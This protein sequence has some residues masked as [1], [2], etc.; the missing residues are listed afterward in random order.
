MTLQQIIEKINANIDTTGNNLTTGAGLIEVLLDM[1]NASFNAPDQATTSLPEYST[2]VNYGIGLAVF[3]N[4]AIYV[5]LE[6]NGPSTIPNGLVEP[7][8]NPDV[9]AALD[10]FELA[11]LQNTDYKLGRYKKIVQPGDLVLGA[12]NLTL[13]EWNR[14]NYFAFGDVQDQLDTDFNVSLQSVDGSAVYEGLFFII[15]EYPNA[16]VT[17]D[18]DGNID[19]PGME[20]L[21]LDQGDWALCLGAV[22]LD[23]GKRTQIIASNKLTVQGEGLNIQ[24]AVIVETTDDP[25][26]NGEN[27]LASYMEA[28]TITPNGEALSATN[29]VTVIIPPGNYDLQSTPLTLDTQF[30]DIVGL[31]S[32]RKKQYIYGEPPAENSGVIVQTANDVR[33]LNFKVEI[34]TIGAG[35]TASS[36][37]AY[38]PNTNLINAYVENVEFVGGTIIEATP[39]LSMRRQVE[40]SGTFYHC[41]G[42]DGAFGGGGTAS[43]TFT[44]C[45]G[46]DETF[47]ESGTASGTFTNCKGE[48]GAFGGYGTASG[49]FTNC[50]GG[51][52]AFGGYGNASGTFSNC[53]GGQTSFGGGDGNL[54]GSLYFCRLTAGTFKAPEEAGKI[55]YCI[56]GNGDVH[57]EVNP[58]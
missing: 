39:C 19:I 31:T 24:S 30:I 57:T 35:F 54:Y 28:K 40:Y 7:G 48:F 51:D 53:I 17:I 44:N 36:S 38:F 25:Q 13:P 22:Q 43:G 6:P 20:D 33:L 56:D 45:T 50:T 29:R 8:T 2:T 46:G 52:E 49:T 32:D 34:M 14:M 5:S 21:V 55:R 27:L 37:S 26:T 15:N 42:G 10:P 58:I 4:N 47:G 16:T 23:G 41:L 18:F 11:H 3:W 12:L 1:I 9:W